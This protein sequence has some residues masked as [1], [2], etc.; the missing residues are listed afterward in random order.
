MFPCEFCEISKNT[1]FH[2][3]LPVAAYVNPLTIQ[4]LTLFFGFFLKSFPILLFWTVFQG[5]SQDIYCNTVQLLTVCQY[6]WKSFIK[7]S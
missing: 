4:K 3:T 7:R 1:F 2:R 6:L 5:I